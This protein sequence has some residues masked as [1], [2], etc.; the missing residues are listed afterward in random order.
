MS[1]MATT[2]TGIETTSVDT[3]T[4]TIDGKKVEAPRGSTVLEAALAAGTY[5]PTL[6][7]DH[8]LK[9]YGACRLCIVEIEGMR[10]LAT[11]CT[12]AATEGMVV[13]TESSKVN[14]SRRITLELIMANHHGDCLTCARNG[15]CE[16]QKVARYLGIEQEHFE[17]LRRSTQVLPI[18][19]SHPL[20]AYPG[21]YAFCRV[22]MRV[23]WR[24][25]GA[26]SH[27]SPGP[28][29]LPAGDELCPNDLPLLRCRLLGIPGYERKRNRRGAG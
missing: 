9:P 8:D 29:A 14:A 25:R 3:I 21:Y 15:E 11:S 5:I 1:A 2:G 12:T 13:H 26:L 6:C 20:A 27:G 18:D 24:V 22:H 7:Y 16:L 10:G 28:E 23:L 4:L 17:R 19:E